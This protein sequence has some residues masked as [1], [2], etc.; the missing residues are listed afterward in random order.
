M[1][2][3]HA[4][5]ANGISYR[6]EC[7]MTSAPLRRSHW[8]LFL[9]KNWFEKEVA[10]Q[11]VLRQ[12]SALGENMSAEKQAWQ[13]QLTLGRQGIQLSQLCDEEHIS[14]L[15]S[16]CDTSRTVS[17]HLSLAHAAKSSFHQ[18]VHLKSSKHR[19]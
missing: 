11:L 14:A 8:L 7:Q 16:H 12:S 9:R 3:Y 19:K 15:L 1:P 2:V 5:S 18:D 6:Q 10:L 4:G 17:T 13:R